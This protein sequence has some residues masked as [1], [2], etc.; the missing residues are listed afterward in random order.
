MYPKIKI[1]LIRA[2][3]NRDIPDNHL[4]LSASQAILCE[5]LLEIPIE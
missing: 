5:T 3:S 4:N 1:I 2:L